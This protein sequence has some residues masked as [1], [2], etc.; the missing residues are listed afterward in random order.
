M[1]TFKKVVTEA[2]QAGAFAEEYRRAVAEGEEEDRIAPKAVSATYDPGS[3]SFTIRL[4]RGGGVIVNLDQLPEL[5]GATPEQLAA[6][7]VGDFLF[8]EDLDVS[9]DLSGLLIDV[10]GR[11]W[12]AREARQWVNREAARAKSEAKAAA[13]RANGAKGGRPRKSREAVIERTA[14]TAVAK[15]PVFSSA[16]DRIE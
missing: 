9:I 7:E 10:I 5:D 15:V 4:A 11:E 8:W 2:P 1:A 12:F 14:D 3:R 13:A 6:V 16:I